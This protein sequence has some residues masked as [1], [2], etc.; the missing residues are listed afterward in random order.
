M[1]KI[2]ETF[3]YCNDFSIKTC[4]LDLA[5]IPPYQPF[6][7]RKRQA[8]PSVDAEDNRK[9]RILDLISPVSNLP[10]LRSTP[11]TQSEYPSPLTAR[12][13]NGTSSSTAK[14]LFTEAEPMNTQDNMD[15]LLGLCSGQFTG[16]I[17]RL[18]DPSMDVNHKGLEDEL[19]GL[20]SGKFNTQPVNL[21][22]LE[23][24]EGLTQPNTQ[25]TE[26]PSKS[27]QVQPFTD[28]E[29]DE[30]VETRVQKRHK[31]L[32]FSDESDDEDAGSDVTAEV[33]DEDEEPKLVDY[34]S[35]ENEIIKPAHE[36]KKRSAAEFFEDE[37][38]LSE[39]EWGSEDEDEQDLDTLEFEE[40]DAENLDQR[41]VKAQLDK[42]HMRRLLDEDRREVRMLQEL[43]LEDG[44]LHSEGGGR[45]RKFRWK[46][47]NNVDDNDLQRRDS[48]NEGN[49]DVENEDEETWRRLRHEREMF[50]Q[51]HKMK[52]GTETEDVL[53][54]TSDS[55]LI[56]LG[57]AAL[58]RINS[59]DKSERLPP[60]KRTVSDPLVSPDPKHPFKLLTKRGSFLA[61]GEN[62]LARIAE[63]TQ[64]S[65]GGPVV[66]PKN[67]RNF[68][69]ATL[70][71]EKVVEKCTVVEEVSIKFRQRKI[72]FL[73]RKLHHTWITISSENNVSI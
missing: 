52:A 56:K 8:T 46:N 34:D 65:S 31:R 29:E 24:D 49:E 26:S 50:L 41:K 12:T 16:S 72:T 66:G 61:R 69:F 2:P 3:T 39:S 73:S 10:S 55:Q 23:Q 44:E 25:H 71:P 60:V 58:K 53:S 17:G 70:S 30:V 1:K 43:L 54:E 7:M 15:E 68:V 59:Q 37:A 33:E 28:D 32:D 62:A 47:I 40:G 45:E 48:D 18:V 22:S 27:K 9:S 57:R 67:T 5:M 19:L 11:S 20:C 4:E 64:N 6:D 35:E 21:H 63:I 36:P 38:E 42:I 51:Q 13:L 14:K